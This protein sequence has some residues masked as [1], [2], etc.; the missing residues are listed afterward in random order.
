VFSV[1][2]NPLDFCRQKT[3]TAAR[4]AI[5]IQNKLIVHQNLCQKGLSAQFCNMVGQDFGNRSSQSKMMSRKK[6]DP[7]GG[8]VFVLLAA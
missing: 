3:A 8:A 1:D 7:N 4:C 2:I 5:E 6:T